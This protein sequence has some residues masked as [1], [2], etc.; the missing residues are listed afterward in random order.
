MSRK[1]T[2]RI[3]TIRPRNWVVSLMIETTKS[4][5]MKDRKKEANKKR[6]RRAV[7]ED[8]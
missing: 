8:E 1:N 3:T 6:C 2:K 7:R 5:P 4:G